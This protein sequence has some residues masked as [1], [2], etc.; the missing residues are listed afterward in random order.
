[1][2]AEEQSILE[3]AQ[4]ERA[5]TILSLIDAKESANTDTQVTEESAGDVHLL[6]LK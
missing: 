5:A 6:A 3:S 4:K 2:R 1:M